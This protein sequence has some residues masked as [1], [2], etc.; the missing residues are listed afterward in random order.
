MNDEQNFPEA[1]PSAP[2]PTAPDPSGPPEP[3]PE[4]DGEEW[5]EVAFGD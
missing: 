4:P 3:T 2:R 1:D 5:D